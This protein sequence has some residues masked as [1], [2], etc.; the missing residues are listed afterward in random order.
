MGLFIGL[1]SG[2][3]I[4]GIDAVLV[5]FKD[6]G[7]SQIIAT[8]GVNWTP[9]EKDMFNS[10]C[11]PGSNEIHR[12]G[13]AGNIY[14]EKAGELINN[15][16][17]ISPFSAEDIEAIGSHGQTIRHEPDEGFTV[18]IGNHAKLA[19]LTNIDV[20][21]DFRSMDIACGGEGAPLVPAF[22][23]EICAIPNRTRFIV[24]IGG[25]ANVT[26]LIPNKHVFGFD[27]GPGNTLMDNVA[28][29]FLNQPCDKG[30]EV[31]SKGD[32]KHDIVN[33]Y[34]QDPYFSK[35]PPKSTGRELFNKDFLNRCQRFNLLSVED[36]LA[37]AT[38]LTAVS[39]INGINS[40]GPRGEI[41]ICG[42]GLHNNFLMSRLEHYANLS[43]HTC[44][45][46]IESIGVDPDYLEAYAFAWLAYKFKRHSP[47]DMS[48][49]TGAKRPSILGCLYP[50]P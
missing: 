11:Q 5:D 9:Q 33:Y 44:L 2:T 22:H 10:L 23:K 17:K 36:K 4:D 46:S 19:A 47:I 50:H 38:E 18:Q 20:V 27:T 8:C 41:Y 43:N 13:L 28:Q 42:G 32:I 40:L 35:Q 31:A 34:L 49:V 3:S 45:K 7:T 26:A 24:N 29:R 1:M 39:I 48:W 37:T 14:A 12:A 25:I 21:C 30:G 15:L 16:L 6:N